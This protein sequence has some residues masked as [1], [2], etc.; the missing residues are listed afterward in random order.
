MCW[1]ATYGRFAVHLLYASEFEISTVV[2]IRFLQKCVTA[3]CVRL[4]S[5]NINDYRYCVC[6]GT[7]N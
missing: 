2:P 6:T 5:N 7:A 1:I 3:L 4:V